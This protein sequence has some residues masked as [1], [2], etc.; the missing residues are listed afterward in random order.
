MNPNDTPTFLAE[1]KTCRLWSRPELV[2]M[3]AWFETL[4]MLA[5]EESPLGDVLRT[6]KKCQEC[7]Q[8]YFHEWYIRG[9]QG[10]YY[11][12]LIPVPGRATAAALAERSIYG[13]MTVFPRLQS[14]NRGGDK[15]QPHWVRGEGVVG[16][17]NASED[18][19]RKRPS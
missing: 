5:D 17:Q 4:E 18:E 10:L 2:D 12:T 19:A 6:L 11:S 1:P 8:L 3:G 13:L 16:Y 7:G 15:S 9:P 14:D